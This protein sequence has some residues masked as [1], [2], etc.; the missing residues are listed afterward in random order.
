[1]VRAPLPGEE[2][3]LTP[4]EVRQLVRECAVV[5]K[6]GETL[7]IQVGPEW[8]PPQIREVSDWLNYRDK[9]GPLWPFRILVIPGERLG[10]V[11]AADA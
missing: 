10:I 6:P 1:M 3:S 2:H 11:E 9:D 4:D 8:N 7:V 5:V